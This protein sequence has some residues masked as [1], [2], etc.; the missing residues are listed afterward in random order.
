MNHIKDTFWLTVIVLSALLLLH[1]LP[2]TIICGHTLRKVDMLSDIR[3]S[4]TDLSVPD[5]LPLV[6]PKSKILVDT[7]KSGITCIEDFTDSIGQGMALFYHALSKLDA[8]EKRIVRIAVFGD[9]FIEGDIFTADLREMLQRKFGGCGVGFIPITS[10][11]SGYRPTV[12]HT[13]GGWNSHAATDTTYFNKKKQG[14]SGH[15]FIADSAA[16]VELRGQAQYAS[17][18]DSCTCAYLL[19]ANKASVKVGIRLN[20]E[21]E[22]L[23][24]VPSSP[25]NGSLRQITLKGH[26]GS[27]RWNIYKADSTVFY[28]AALE[29]SKGI[30]LDNFSLRG[31]SGVS[32]RYIP[33]QTLKAFSSKRPYDL[34]ILQYGLNVAT[35]KGRNYDY[36]RIG[37]NKSIA[38]IKKCFPEAAI[39]ML[40][41][42][43]RSYKTEEGELKTMPGV[44]NLI[45]Y[46]KVIA[47]ESSV[48]FWNMFQAMGGEGAMVK[49]V[50]AKPSLANY[51]YTHINFRGG[52]YLAGLLYESL[53]YGYEQHKRREDYAK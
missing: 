33:E 52:K 9:S 48:A 34:I 37:M 15:Y 8:G 44:K 18:L 38:H 42:G 41:V 7:C 3:S 36:Y 31:S 12:K 47:S 11:T 23:V 35:E 26:I 6:A 50:H 16:F 27:V 49:M 4:K 25:S 29:G 51:D 53:M 24:D 5:T 13:Y 45:Q 28:G 40:G 39:L 1:Y 43:D 2:S 46:Q 10:M 14:I 30:V 22:K 17:L 20:R 19:F 32:L 21:I